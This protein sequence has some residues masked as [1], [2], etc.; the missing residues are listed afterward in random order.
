MPLIEHTLI[1]ACVTNF[2]LNSFKLPIQCHCRLTILINDVYY[3][4]MTYLYAVN[5]AFKNPVVLDFNPPPPSSIVEFCVR[6]FHLLRMSHV[7]WSVCWA[8]E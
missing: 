3:T 8:H 7:A 5:T 1:F 4:G 2:S 6:Q